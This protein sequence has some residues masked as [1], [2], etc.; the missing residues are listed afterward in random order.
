MF[1]QVARVMSGL[2]GTAIVVAAPLAAHAVYP[3]EGRP[4][5]IVIGFTAGGATDGQARS[6]AQQ[7]SE[8]LKT[9]V[10]VENRPGASTIVATSTVIRAEPDGYTLLYSPS[11][12]MAQNP[13]TLVQ[14]TYD[15]F[16]DLTPI[17]LAARGPLVLV[18]SNATNAKTVAELVEYVKAHPGKLSYASFGTG[19][20]SHVIGEMFAQ[21][22]G[23]DVQ[24]IPYKGGADASRDLLSGRVAYMFDAAPNAIVA[25]STGRAKMLAIPAAERSPQLAEIPTLTEAGTDIALPSWMGFYG[26]ANLPPE[27]V[28]TLNKAIRTSLLAEP[29]ANFFSSGAYEVTPSSPDELKTIMRDTYD[30]WGDVIKQAGIEKQ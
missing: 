6:V 8:V 12:T 1:T 25:E 10:I 7:L 21:K 13:H 16:N 23:L 20:S 2:V 24:H 26:P 14:A 5:R 18:A 19:T 30:L 3:E 9:P 15:P 29:V 17:S 27:I 4:I 22:N 28:E 11:S